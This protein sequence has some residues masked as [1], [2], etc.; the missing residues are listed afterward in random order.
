MSFIITENNNN[1]INHSEKKYLQAQKVTYTAEIRN[2]FALCK[3]IQTY[4]VPKS[5]IDEAVYEFPVDYNSAFCDL[6]IRTRGKEIHGVVK[7]KSEAKKIY[8]ETKS[9]GNQA[10]LCEE[11]ASDRDIY[12]LIMCNIFNGDIID[13]EY[14]YITELE[15]CNA[16]DIFLIPSFISPRYQGSF[17]PN[18]NHSIETK[19]VIGGDPN[20]LICSVANVLISVED[21]CLVLRHKSSV[22]LDKDIEIKFESD[23]T[24]RAYKFESKGL[25]MAMMQFY[26]I[27]NS[28]IEN[29][30]EIMFILDC[31][32]S[33]NGARIK[34][35]RTA[36]IHCLN[37]LIGNNK[38]RFNILRYGSTCEFYSHCMLD[39]DHK[40]IN[41]AIKYCENIEADLRGTMT[42]EA[43]KACLKHSK[44]SIL[45]TDGDT[46]NNNELYDLCKQFDC[47]SV[48]GIGSG[49]NRANINDMAKNGSGIARYSQTDI[50]I[51]DNVDI[52]FNSMTSVSIKKY[53]IDW[54]NNGQ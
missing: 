26:P 7:E 48:L 24:P 36:M 42:T 51:V 27:S 25:T 23:H 18:P 44:T 50:D 21:D 13:I 52:I 34:N 20:N 5:V 43:L 14:T 19:I 10:F 3:L 37:K 11:N 12:R 9:C 32:G 4:H 28:T 31:S 39:T 47:L 35:S 6:V 54:K 17:V 49:I 53:A 38:Y 45:I 41:D 1:N 16:Q 8:S 22:T 40:T 2:G 15:C 33:M 46:S 29:V 30:K